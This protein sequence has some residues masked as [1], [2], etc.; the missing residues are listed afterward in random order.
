LF[1]SNVAL[2][3]ISRQLSPDE[4]GGFQ[5]YLEPDMQYAWAKTDSYTAG[6]Q[7]AGF[8]ACNEPDNSD[9]NLQHYQPGVYFELP[10]Q[11]GEWEVDSL[12]SY[13]FAYDIFGGT[14]LGTRHELAASVTATDPAGHRW[15]VFWVGDMT[16]FRDDGDD[17]PLTSLD[18][19]TQTIGVARRWQL[20]D[21]WF[22][23]VRFSA[24]GQWAELTGADQAYRGVF[25]LLTTACVLSECWELR[26]ELGWG[27]RSYPDFTG[28]PERN[29][30]IWRTRAEFR[31]WLSDHCYLSLNGSYDRFDS[32][33]DEY[34]AERFTVGVSA[35]VLH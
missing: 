4:N 31:R 32:A 12:L 1:N 26:P 35:T 15:T 21:S 7:F 10:R 14:T 5:A 33:N 19:P 9:F 6:V 13:D 30:S 17:P 3:P 23:N 18:G 29:E 8:F 28:T 34:A 25:L 11:C 22:D 24:D 27:F 20:Y 16:E 2:A